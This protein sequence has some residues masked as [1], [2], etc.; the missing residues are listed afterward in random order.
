VEVTITYVKHQGRDFG[1]VFAREKSDEVVDFSLQKSINELKDSNEILQQEI[2]ALKRKE[3][4]LETSLSLLRSH[5][6]ISDTK[7][8]AS[9]ILYALT[10]A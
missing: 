2:T 9:E 5:I 7:Q 8:T 1:Y 6:D 10:Q 3:I 4:K